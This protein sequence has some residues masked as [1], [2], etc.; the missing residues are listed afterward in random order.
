MYRFRPSGFTTSDRTVLFLWNVQ[1]QSLGTSSLTQNRPIWTWPDACAKKS[2]WVTFLNIPIVRQHH[3][4]QNVMLMTDIICWTHEIQPVAKFNIFFFT[5]FNTP[6]CDVG[7]G[8]LIL[9]PNS[10]FWCRDLSPASQ[11]QH[12]HIWSSASNIDVS[13]LTSHLFDWIRLKRV[14]FVLYFASFQKI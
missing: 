6:R 13:I 2:V 8:Y 1:F 10:W 11:T 14:T 4:C 3:I 12:Q 5:I 7:D 9:V